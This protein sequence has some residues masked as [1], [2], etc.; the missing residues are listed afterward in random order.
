MTKKYVIALITT[1]F[2]GILAVNSV[3]ATN[4]LYLT[5]N[6]SAQEMEQSAEKA[7]VLLV[8]SQ[9]IEENEIAED[10]GREIDL[11]AIKERVKELTEKIPETYSSTEEL[12]HPLKNRYLMYS[13]DGKHVMWGFYRNGFFVGKDNHGKLC[14]GIYGKNIFAGFYDGEFFWGKYGRGFW[15]AT[16]L[17]GE[18]L[19]WGRYVLFPIRLPAIASVETS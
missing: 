16:G 12:V 18:R 13:H 7:N 9:P 2:L 5:R 17:F 19:T 8:D 11:D 4:N 10:G 15:K 1:L 6:I 14:W 3:L